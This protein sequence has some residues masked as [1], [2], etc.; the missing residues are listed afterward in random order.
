MTEV[1]NE[2][3]FCNM[4]MIF[5]D[6]HKRLR[7]LKNEYILITNTKTLTHNIYYARNRIKL[8]NNS[9]EYRVKNKQMISLK[10][11]EYYKKNK[12]CLT[13]KTEEYAVKNIER[14][15]NYKN[16]VVICECGLS[17]TRS[18]IKRHIKT[19]TH[20]RHLII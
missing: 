20:V 16:T 3:R 18:N 13:L 6:L 4:I 10:R 9:R 14:I 1:T 17:C 8:I 11:K 15:K 2:M 5:E 7:K 19:K 12:E